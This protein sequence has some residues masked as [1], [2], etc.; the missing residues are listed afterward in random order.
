MI[1]VGILA[2]VLR[3]TLRSDLVHYNM[4]D[5]ELVSVTLMSFVKWVEHGTYNVSEILSCVTV[6]S[7]ILRTF[8]TGNVFF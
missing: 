8:T 6:Y 7:T 5:V 2:L 3:Q 1:R 4:K